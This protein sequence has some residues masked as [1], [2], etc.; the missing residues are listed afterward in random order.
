MEE[1]KRVATVP[2]IDINLIATDTKGYRVSLKQLRCN[3]ASEMLGIWITPNGDK[4]KTIK[5]LKVAALDWAGKMRMD[6]STVEEAWTALH[7]NIGAKLKCP[8]PTCT[9]T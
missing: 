8:L 2:M 1:G 4:K 7:T 6:H 5:E 9:L 3:E